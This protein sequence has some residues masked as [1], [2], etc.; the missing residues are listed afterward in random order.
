MGALGVEKVDAVLG[1]LDIDGVLVGAVLEDEL[2]EV[3]EG[4]L[5]GRP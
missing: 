2:L 1:L 3:E 4:A 5:V